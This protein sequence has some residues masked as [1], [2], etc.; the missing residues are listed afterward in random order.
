MP[1]LDEPIRVGLRGHEEVAASEIATH[2]H[3]TVREVERFIGGCPPLTE[4][5]A[6]GSEL[7]V[8]ATPA[9]R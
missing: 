1:V 5:R 2:H 7:T 8:V 4:L 3:T 6:P 9:T